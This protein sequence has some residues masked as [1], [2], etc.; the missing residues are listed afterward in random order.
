MLIFILFSGFY[1]NTSL[2]PVW[3]RWLQWISPMRYT[4]SALVLNQ[5][6]GLNFTCSGAEPTGCIPN[7]AVG[8]R[9]EE[10]SIINVGRP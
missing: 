3:L 7:G 5:F 6:T 1:A 2:I 4:Y 8:G 9:K 10:D